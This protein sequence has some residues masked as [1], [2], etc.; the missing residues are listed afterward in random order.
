MSYLT[1][2]LVGMG[3]DVLLLAGDQL[4]IRANQGGVVVS[5]M[6]RNSPAFQAGLQPLD[7]V[8]AFNGQAISDASQL[9]RLV[10]DA[11]IGAPATFRIMRDGR[12]LDLKIPVQS[13]AAR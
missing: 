1:E 11:K 7:V 8:V 12:S 10:Q 4:G 3:H 2:A 5:R 6:R 13:T 9:Q